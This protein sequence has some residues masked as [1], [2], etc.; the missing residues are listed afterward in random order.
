MIPK[1]LLPAR[2]HASLVLTLSQLFIYQSLVQILAVNQ[3]LLSTSSGS[4]DPTVESRE[5]W[6]KVQRNCHSLWVMKLGWCQRWMKKR[7]DVSS[8]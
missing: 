1:G 7:K 8:R 3:Y 4:T 5:E 2:Y 6:S